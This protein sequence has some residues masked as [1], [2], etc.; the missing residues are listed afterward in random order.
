MRR[1][2]RRRYLPRHDERCAER[3][4]SAGRSTYTVAIGAPDYPGV[5]YNTGYWIANSTIAGATG[6]TTGVFGGE[7]TSTHSYTATMTAPAAEGVYYYKVFGVE[8]TKS[9]SDYTSVAV[10]SIVVDNTAPATGHNADGKTHRTFDLVLTPT[11][12]AAGVA[13]TSYRIDGGTWRY[14]TMARLAVA[15][16]R[17]RGLGA[18]THS[19]EYFSPDIA[20]NV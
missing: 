13:G 3:C 6:T 17:N 16:K 1:L 11:D 15:G 4:V 19:V 2:S 7:T 10:Y 9:T 18:G 8:G 5:A 14:G 12:N 20:G